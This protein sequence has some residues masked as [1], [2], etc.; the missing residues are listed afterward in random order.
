MF[1][2]KGL[3]RIWNINYLSYIFSIEYYTQ[4]FWRT[5]QFLADS[6]FR[7][8]VFGETQFK[9]TKLPSNAATLFWYSPSNE[10]K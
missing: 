10:F 3:I 7:E 9:L 1:N 2:K 8:A 6:H 5:A 4:F